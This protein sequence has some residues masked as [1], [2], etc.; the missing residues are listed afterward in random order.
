VSE[1]QVFVGRQEELEQFKQV[2]ENPQGQAILVIGQQGMGKTFLVNKMAEIAQN[3]P[4]IKCGYVRY[5]VTPTDSVDS[6]MAL[7]MDNAFDA[8]NTEPGSFD[9]VPERKKQW[10][11]L[12]KLTTLIPVAGNYAEKL[13]ELASSLKHDSARNTREQFLDRLNLISKRMPKDG[14]AI[15][16]IDPEKYIQK[17]CD[18]S[19]AIVVK[20]LPEKIKFV[21]AQRSEDALVDSETFNKLKNVV[22]IPEN[23]LDVL[24]E[25][26]VDELINFESTQIKYPIS[27]IKKVILGYKGHPYAVGAALGLLKAGTKLE[28]LPKHNKPVD[29][30][31]AQWNKICEKGDD[32]IALFEAYTILE[33]GVPDDIAGYVSE[34]NPTTLKRLQNDNYLKGLLR[35]E[36]EG[37]RIY[38]SILTDHILGQMSDNEKKK[39]HKKAVK[40]YRG[41]LK[42]AGEEKI[43][44]DELAATRLPEHV[45]A[46]E[47]E[48]AFVDIFLNE[49]GKFLHTL[50]TLDTF[51]A[52]SE[53]VLKMVEKGSEDEAIIIGNLGLIYY[54]RGDLGEAEKMHKKSLAI[55]EKLGRLEGMAD[56]YGNLGNVYRARG[57]LDK[58]EE[59]YNKVLDIEKKLGRPDSIANTYGNLGIVYYTR[60]N[61]NEAEKMHKKALAINEKL[62]RLE[63]MASNYGGLGNVYYIRGDLDEAEKMHKKSLA[64]SE[65]IGH[66]EGM[67][68][69]Y[70]NLGLIYQNRN[71][72]KKAKEYL[73]KARDLYEKI[74]AKHMVKQVQGFIDEAGKKKKD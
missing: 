51:I 12:F 9:N 39:Y 66:L 74:G 21:F 69:Q 1:K 44:P 67:A 50:G 22:R 32:A 52:L 62:G 18:Q 10:L 43:K 8:A 49:C 54:T 29:F 20:D 70:S 14:R 40:I 30:A 36:G 11:A 6:T 28:E 33:V 37:K 17:D 56:Q 24:D 65:K 58:A 23:H 71:D 16:I 5:E 48:D 3:H 61:L 41:K 4:D 57:D 46:A 35:E 27:D 73:V 63:G 7:M 34:L 68:I 15:F 55:N 47:G 2:L 64:I 19:W 45:L 26:A 38:H 53:R 25:S 60:G 31:K 59:M 13:I 42:R 72:L